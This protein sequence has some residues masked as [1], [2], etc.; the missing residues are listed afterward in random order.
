MAAKFQDYYSV[1]G[2]GKKATDEEIKKAFRA[3]ALK[4]HPDVAKD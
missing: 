1:L 2:V 3:L 4:Y